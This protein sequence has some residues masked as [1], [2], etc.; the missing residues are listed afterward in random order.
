MEEEIFDSL[1]EFGIKFWIKDGELHFKYPEGLGGEGKPELFK[2]IKA[3]EKE[4][5]EFLRQKNIFIIRD[6]ADGTRL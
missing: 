1:V 3:H 6:F 4:I 5:M 2:F